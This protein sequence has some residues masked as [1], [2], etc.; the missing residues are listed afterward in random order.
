MGFNET[1]DLIC[2]VQKSISDFDSDLLD[3]VIVQFY[4]GVVSV[5]PFHKVE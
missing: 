5:K 4:H 3:G 2:H 1:I